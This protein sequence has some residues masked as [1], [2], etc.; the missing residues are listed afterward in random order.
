MNTHAKHNIIKKPTCFENPD[1]TLVDV[2]VTSNKNRFLK[3]GSFNTGL[4]DFHHLIYGVLHT[5]FP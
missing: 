2:I 4:S 1:G 5:G 3:S